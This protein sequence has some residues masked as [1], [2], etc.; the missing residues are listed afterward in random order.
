MWEEYQ[1]CVGVG[2][3]AKSQKIIPQWMKSLICVLCARRY[4]M[5]MPFT[6]ELNFKLV[7]PHLTFVLYYCKGECEHCTPGG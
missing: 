7:L 5:A 3:Q 2:N 1:L 4:F 6:K